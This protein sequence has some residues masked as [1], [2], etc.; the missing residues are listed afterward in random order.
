MYDIV[1]HV[2]ESLSTVCFELSL[3]TVYGIHVLPFDK[4]FLQFS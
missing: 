2:I 3:T 4:D 1:P